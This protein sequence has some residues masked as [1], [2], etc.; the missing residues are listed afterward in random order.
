MDNIFKYIHF[1]FLKDNQPSIYKRFYYDK[2]F[3]LTYGLYNIPWGEKNFSDLIYKLKYY[4]NIPS[5]CIILSI[6]YM[7]R[8]IV[9]GLVI[10]EFNIRNIFI[11]CVLISYKFLIDKTIPIL[12]YSNI[13][14]IPVKYLIKIE[15]YIVKLMSYKL[16]V[17]EFVY[18]QLLNIIRNFA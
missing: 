6:V 3:Y 12:F 1:L 9:N 15:L 14:N 7:K 4:L 16:F 5:E 17:D 2:M 10:T 11:V 8:L 18:Y 13:T